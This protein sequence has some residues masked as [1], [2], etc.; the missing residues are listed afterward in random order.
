MP[1]RTS[2]KEEEE[3]NIYASNR[4]RRGSERCLDRVN[5]PW[6]KRQGV[7]ETPNLFVGDFRLSEKI[8]L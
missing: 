5:E 6:I 1:T 3:L 8:S 2:Y 4:L 7:S